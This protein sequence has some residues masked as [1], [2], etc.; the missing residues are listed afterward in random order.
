MEVIGSNYFGSPPKQLITNYQNTI[1]VMFYIDFNDDY[2]TFYWHTLQ[3]DGGIIK[4][5][6][7]NQT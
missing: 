5:Y 1:L 7:N 3:T 4:S 6:A 2:M